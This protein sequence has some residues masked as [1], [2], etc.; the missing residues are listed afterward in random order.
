MLHLILIEFPNFNV[1]FLKIINLLQKYNAVLFAYLKAKICFKLATVIFFDRIIVGFS[2]V[3]RK[4]L[5]THIF[6]RPE[7]CQ[8]PWINIP[9]TFKILPSAIIPTSKIQQNKNSTDF[10]MLYALFEMVF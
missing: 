2:L 3:S 6:N 7:I 4:S 10:T 1:E 8:T 9:N 5:F